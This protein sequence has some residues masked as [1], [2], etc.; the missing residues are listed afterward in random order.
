ML[1]DDLFIEREE[2]ESDPAVKGLIQ[3]QFTALY[4]SICDRGYQLE[5]FSDKGS[6]F[7]GSKSIIA[8]MELGFNN[9]SKMWQFSIEHFV[10]EYK[11]GRIPL[12]YRNKEHAL[13]ARDQII[14]YQQNVNRLLGNWVDHSKRE[15]DAFSK[16]RFQ[17]PS[18]F[19]ANE[20]VFKPMSIF[21][22]FKRWFKK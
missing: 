17:V 20:P 12:A 21:D 18:Q 22:R 3:K 15:R 14:H 2:A 5:L 1:R 10:S 7:I 9:Q 11:A 4:W 19:V 8:V 13:S 16:N 6:I